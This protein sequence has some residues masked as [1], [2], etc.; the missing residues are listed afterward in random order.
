MGVH[1]F[2]VRGWGLLVKHE[3]PVCTIRTLS[4][5][6]E[7]ECSYERLWLLSLKNVYLCL[8]VWYCMILMIALHPLS[9]TPFL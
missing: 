1:G 9:P 6:Y 5:E 8:L 4:Q 2:L 3:P 7:S